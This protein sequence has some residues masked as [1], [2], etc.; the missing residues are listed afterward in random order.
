VAAEA[1][2]LAGVI[3]SLGVCALA[4][5]APFEALR[6]LIRLPGQ[7]LSSVEAVIVGLLVVW[8][9]V[10][11][12]SR[13][14]PDWRT[15]LTIPWL[16]FGAAGFLAALLAP[17]RPNALRAVGRLAFAFSIFVATWS[18][19]STLTR[20]RRAV[21]AFAVA[22][23]IVSV[24]IVLDYGRVS[25]VLR[26]LQVFRTGDAVVGSLVRA[27]GPF[28][29]PTIASMYLEIVFALLLG[30][31]LVIVDEGR[32]ALA[33]MV[34]VVTLLVGEAIA[35]TF[36]RTGLLTMTTSLVVVGVHRY[37]RPGSRQG[38]IAIALVSVGV[39]ILAAT[40]QSSEAIRVRM[41]TEGQESWYRATIDAPA[42]MT[43]SAGSVLRVPIRVTNSGRMTW[44]ASGGSQFLVS[45]H[46]LEADRDFVVSW[47]AP[48]EPLT[49]EVTPGTTLPFEVTL[50]A[51]RQPG[52]YR[53]LWDIKQEHRFWFSTEPGALLPTTRATVTGSSAVQEPPDPG[54]LRGQPV[55]K[56]AVRPTRLP[57]WRAAARM[58]AARPVT[59]YGPDNF[60]LHYGEYIG[61]GNYDPR[62]HSNNMYLEVL[63]GGG[64]VGFITF[65]WLCRRAGEA[66]V[67][68]ARIREDAVGTFGVSIAAAGAAIAL[69]GLVDSFLTFTATYTTFAIVLGLA[70]SCHGL[71][72]RH[73]NRV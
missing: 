59:G 25:A 31:L 27:S 47:N 15:P 32:L 30:L 2:I 63:A 13:V 20:L 66:F 23:A 45:Y 40:S 34:G 24:L 26:L 44:A 71:S 64:L 67:A 62:V 53:V 6:P 43:M 18:G 70:V 56:P 8:G 38:L 29:Y 12:A 28:Q 69:H 41:T 52:R 42:G 19:V 49:T 65:L 68:A 1:P 46:W 60:R 55:P 5:V 36:T 4:L 22:G 16:T 61:A 51:P 35:L 17:D 73:A 57:L 37:L 33:V 50:V 9:G 58:F 7:S 11:F 14:F 72:T 48:S 3:S 21:T 10:L 54:S 39:L